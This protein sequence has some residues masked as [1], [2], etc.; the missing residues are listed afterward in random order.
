LCVFELG[1]IRQY[2][3]QT[4][5]T[6]EPV[7]EAGSASTGVPQVIA[8]AARD[9]KLLWTHAFDKGS[10]YE[11][12]PT[13]VIHA[14]HVYVTAE[15][16]GC[17]LLEVLPAGKDLFGVK[18]L[19]T[20]KARKLMDNWHAGVVLVGKHIYGFSHGKGWVCQELVTGKAAWQ[21]RN[22]LPGSS[23]SIIAAD[24]RLYLLSD[25][26]VV[27]LLKAS[28]NGWQE[29]GRFELP[30][31]SK[32][33]EDRPTSARGAIWTQPVIA[34]GRLYLRDQELLFCYDIRATK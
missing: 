30:Q 2:V 3:T 33:R 28:P 1:G 15:A 17:Q 5:A 20:G 25:E 21:E 31:K 13:P 23:G 9:G 29:T 32:S 18:A 12:T 8:V 16:I 4:F 11:L 7:P 19:Y 6:E 24:D 22:Q 10:Y 14:N 27:A 34:N 26:G